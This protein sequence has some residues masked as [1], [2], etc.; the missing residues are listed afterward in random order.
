MLSTPGGMSV[1]SATSSPRIA[2]HQGVSGAGLR[3]TVLPA[4]SAGPI[5]ARLIWCGK[6]HGVIAPTTPTASRTM[7]RWVVIPIGAATPE[8]GAPRIGLGGVGGE[9]QIFDRTFELRRRGQHPGRADLGD[10]DLAQFLDVLAHGVAQLADAA[11]PQLGV[12]RPVGVVE[13]AAGGV[14]RAAHVV[15]VG[16][17]GGAQDLLGRRVDGRESARAAGH[18]LAVDEEIAVAVG[19]YRHPRLPPLVGHLSEIAVSRTLV[20][21]PRPDARAIAASR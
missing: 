17:G 9:A 11:H 12:R 5:L 13:R 14:D 7:V 1:C 21:A 3:T 8:I 2:A 10:G 15:G 4:A 18:E 16:V 20:A 19:C 6:F